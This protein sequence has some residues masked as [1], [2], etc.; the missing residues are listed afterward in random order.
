[1]S[2]IQNLKTVLDKQKDIL[3][4]LE[5]EIAGI[6]ANDLVT[7]NQKLKT[8]LTKYH[9]SLNKVKSDNTR[10]TEENKRLRTALYEQFYNEKIQVL[11]AAE[12]RMDVYYRSNFEGEI[13]RL[14]KLEIHI[15][16]KI[17]EMAKVLRENRVSIEDE[18]FVRLEE[19]R[20]QLNVKVAKAREEIIR[21]TKAYGEIKADELSK[22]KQEQV[23][24]A[25][26]RARTK[27]NN[28][29]SLIGLNIIN[30]LGILL[31]IIGIITAAQFT[32]FRLPDTLKGIFTFAVGILLLITG[33][34]LNRKKPNVFS[35]GI[36]SGGVAVLYVALVLS[37]FQ[38]N[39]LGMYQALGLCVLITAGAFVLSQRYNSQTIS[40]FAMIGGYLPIF[41]IAGSKTMVY[42]A[43]VYFVVLNLLALIISVNKK[44][45][46]TAYIGFVLNVIG[47]IYI[48]E[49]LLDG[50]P[51]RPMFTSDG[52]ITIFYILFA[53]IIYTLIPITGTYTKK[54]GFKNSDIVLLSLNTFISSFLL[55]V[56]LYSVDLKD[57]TGLLSLV[58]SIVYLSLGRFIE[59]N[60]E[61]EKNSGG[62]VLYHRTYLCRINYTLPIGKGMADIGMA[63][64]GN[65]NSFLWNIQGIKRL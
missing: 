43:M 34:L 20:T 15:K 63:G 49:I 8:D 41:S 50:T 52:L 13:N 5:K 48:S 46:V 38:F 19:L 1:M 4:S 10:L 18:I 24:E 26:I 40:T 65:C 17:N 45:M 12:K 16:N 60:M 42:G 57:F 61:K 30:K 9:E 37:Y 51:F 3:A 7:E 33:E 64:R 62:F 22:L 14:T 59:K 56:A 36:T 53:F 25:E 39:I 47:S 6:E 54:I 35:L 21:Q 27:Q 32:Y 31:L 11:N 55:Y 58:L 28:I 29:E 44:W 2:M 23:T